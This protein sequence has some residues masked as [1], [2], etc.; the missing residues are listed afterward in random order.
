MVICNYRAATREVQWVQLHP[1]NFEKASIAPINFRNL[2]VMFGNYYGIVK[3]CTHQFGSLAVA[4]VKCKFYKQMTGSSIS[5]GLLYST[6]PSLERVPRVPRHPLKFGN[7]C[8]APVPIRVKAN[9]TEK[10]TKNV[11]QIIDFKSK[12]CM[13]NIAKKTVFLGKGS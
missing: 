6:G 2:R 1:S 11:S 5:F 3:I 12:V 13:V 9:Q 10:F 4:L 7:R 8:Q